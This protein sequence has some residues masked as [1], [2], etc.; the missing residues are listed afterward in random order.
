MSELGGNGKL[1]DVVINKLTRYYGCAV[2]H[3]INGTVKE[4]INYILA[5]FLHCSSNDNNP[6]HMFCPKTVD[7]WCFYQRAIARKETPA[8]HKQ[9]KVR[10]DVR[11]EMRSRVY[12]EYKRLT[13]DKLLSACLLGKTQNPNEHLHSRIWR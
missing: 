1:T 2:R 9:M 8:S 6:R 5:S 12:G 3:N 7:S 4:M 13:T 11:P 10:F